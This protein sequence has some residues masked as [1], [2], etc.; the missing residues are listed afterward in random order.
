MSHIFISIFRISTVYRENI[1]SKGSDNILEDLYGYIEEHFLKPE[2]KKLSSTDSKYLAGL[3]ISN[4]NSVQLI[5]WFNNQPFHA[6]PISLG[7][8]HNA[9]IQAK[10]GADYS[11]HVTNNPLPFRIESI[12]AIIS[13]LAPNNIGYQLGKNIPFALALIVSIFV[14]FYVKERVSKSKLLQ[15]LGGVNVLTFWL[16]SFL[17]DFVTFVLLAIVMVFTLHSLPGDDNKTILDA[18]STFIVLILFGFSVLPIIFLASRLIS[19]PSMGYIQ[20]TV[21]FLSTGKPFLMANCL[22]N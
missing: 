7:L 4:K 1:K 20:M 16:T 21:F 8:V 19:N 10:L 12:E 15:Y 2:N 14:M 11:I 3:S 17:F 18:S 6:A 13:S 5:A 9:T 22:N